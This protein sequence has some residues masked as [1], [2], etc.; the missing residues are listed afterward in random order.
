MKT[1]VLRL[2]LLSVIFGLTVAVSHT[3][4]FKG[5]LA[6]ERGRLGVMLQEVDSRLK[7]KK[8]LAVDYGVFI[9]EVEE[10]SPAEK[11]G[12]VV[13]DVIVKFDDQRIDDSNDLI[14]AVRSAESGNDL[15]VGLYRGTEQKTV[16]VR[17]G[18]RAKTFAFKHSLPDMDLD[19]EHA[20]PPVMPFRYRMRSMHEVHGLQLQELNR[21]LADY[22][23]VPDRRGI[24][25]SEVE[26]ASPGEKSGFK[27][28]DVILKVNGSSVRDLEDIR[29]EL[30]ESEKAEVPIDVL[31]RGKPMTLILFIDEEEDDMSMNSYSPRGRDSEYDAACSQ[32]CCTSGDHTSLHQKLLCLKNLVLAKIRQIGLTMNRG[33]DNI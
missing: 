14:R 3:Q 28:G 17:L 31:R 18:K 26:K 30:R 27:A 32:Q 22:F 7:E 33:F 21:Q 16:T 25:V 11:G 12:I 15:K 4:T 8:K 24:L 13:G 10:G 6:V 23:E 1:I 20:E 19:F 29:E 9:S 5:K 2:V